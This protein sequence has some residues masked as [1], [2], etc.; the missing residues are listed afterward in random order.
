MIHVHFF[1]DNGRHSW[2]PAHHMIPFSGIEDFRSRASLIT[3][4]TRKKDP[5]LVAAL[6]IK[7]SYF[8]AW[9]KAVAEAMDV[10]YELDMSALDDFKPQLKD[11]TNNV[12]KK[13]SV[14][15][16]RKRKSDDNQNIK[17][18]SCDILYQFYLVTLYYMKNMST[19]RFSK[20]TT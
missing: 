1:N 3:D 2:I 7:P 11:L 13:T 15:R 17:K 6:S 8:E 10:L 20:Q 9:Q 14:Q 12:P 18:V 4:E 19:Y 5:K 16:K